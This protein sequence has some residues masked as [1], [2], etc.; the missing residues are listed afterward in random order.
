MEFVNKTFSSKEP[1]GSVN[2][3]FEG[4]NGCGI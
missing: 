4:A 2:S 3:A 1:N